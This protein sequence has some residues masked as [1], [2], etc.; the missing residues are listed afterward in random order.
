M[1]EDSFEAKFKCRY[2]ESEP[3]Y[4]KIRPLATSLRLMKIRLAEKATLEP[5]NLEDKQGRGC[6]EEVW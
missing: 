6:E 4:Q 1:L 3:T 2:N 5:Q